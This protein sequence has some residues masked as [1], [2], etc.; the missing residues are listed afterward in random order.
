MF[1]PASAL[2][3]TVRLKALLMGRAGIGKTN[4]AVT[5]CPRPVGVI[6]CEGDTALAYPRTVLRDDEG[7]SQ[8]QMD[9]VL[10]FQKVDSWD[11]MMKAVVEAR[12]AAEAG[13]IQTVVVDPLN[14]FADRL[15][16]QCFQWYKT[17]EGNEDGRKAHPECAKRLR[18]LCHQLIYALPCH[19]IVVS[20]YLD[21]GDAAKK[22]GPDKVPLLPNQE[23]RSVV[24][25]M[26]PH[27]IWMDLDPNGQRIFVMTP[28]GFTG[29]GV[30]GYRGAESMTAD[31][32]GL[33]RALSL[34]G[35]PEPGGKPAFVKPRPNGQHAPAAHAP[36]HA[37]APVAARPSPQAARPA[38][39]ARPASP[40]PRGPAT[41]NRTQPT[42]RR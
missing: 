6:L 2:E 3:E 41:P 7:L 9:E 28:N 19:V 18:Q 35:A 12:A 27:K 1:Q 10:K 22:G 17:K 40:P 8:K 36:V 4:V 13:E 38:P 21:V 33:M 15:I 31:F 16:D 11:S 42:T 37:P 39:A 25:G 34:P 14:F 26:F 5:T 23:S 32:G 20:H 29:P 24:H 30:R